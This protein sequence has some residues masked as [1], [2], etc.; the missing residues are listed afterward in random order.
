L[1][2]GGADKLWRMGDN[3]A[4]EVAWDPGSH[5][6]RDARSAVHSLFSTGKGGWQIFDFVP[7][8][9]TLVLNGQREKSKERS[10][11]S[12]T[13]PDRRSP[14]VLTSRRLRP[15]TRYSRAREVPCDQPNTGTR[16]QP[17]PL[18]TSRRFGLH[19]RP[20]KRVHMPHGA[21]HGRDREHSMVLSAVSLA[22]MERA[23]GNLWTRVACSAVACA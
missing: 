18:R 8:L 11:K 20:D 3:P 9:V 5:R 1:A 12:K 15:R 21:G 17:A 22:W 10:A 14:L 13:P 4:L 19:E 6:L 16:V 7:Q 23:H 2:A